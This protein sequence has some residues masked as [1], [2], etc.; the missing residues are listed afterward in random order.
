[1]EDILHTLQKGE[2]PE[3]WNGHGIKLMHAMGT[4]MLAK[5][6]WKAFAIDP[7]ALHILD[8]VARSSFT[9]YCEDRLDI[10][11][12]LEEPQKGRGIEY[13]NTASFQK[14]LDERTPIAGHH[15]KSDAPAFGYFDFV[16]RLGIMTAIGHKHEKGS[17]RSDTVFLEHSLPEATM[18]SCAG[19]LL[20][21]IVETPITKGLGLKVLSIEPTGVVKPGI[22]IKSDAKDHLTI[23]T[24]RN[25]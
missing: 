1:M 5:S 6:G 10:T 13:L 23:I 2:A 11:L 21:A 12:R 9:M 4:R 14:K 17:I 20:D 25:A 8:R 18:L 3:Q 15:R 19:K 24:S 16:R 7:I 22:A